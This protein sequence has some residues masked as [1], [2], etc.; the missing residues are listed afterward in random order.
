[1]NKCA[2]CE[3]EIPDDKWCCDDCFSRYDGEVFHDPLCSEGIQ[4]GDQT[5]PCDC[6]D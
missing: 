2:D 4:A 1:M 3:C 6:Q 5:M